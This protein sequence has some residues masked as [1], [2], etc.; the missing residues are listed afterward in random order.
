MDND[1]EQ[2]G[3]DVL[4][5]ILQMKQRK[6][7]AV[8]TPAEIH[9]RRGRPKG[10]V[11]AKTKVPVKLRLDPDV[12]Q[13]MRASGPGWQTRAN[14]LLREHF[15]TTA[16][17]S[18]TFVQGSYSTGTRL[19]SQTNAWLARNSHPAAG[20]SASTFATMSGAP[21]RSSLRRVPSSRPSAVF[22]TASA[23]QI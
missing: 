5:S 18:S 1:I 17:S 10:S 3:A 19:F 4:K 9:A 11:M 7:A 15:V 21:V 14:E 13:A 12:L 23:A 22:E 20:A 6:A 8:H 16:P 2:F